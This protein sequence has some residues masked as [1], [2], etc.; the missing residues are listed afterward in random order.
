MNDTIHCSIL[1][2][3]QAVAFCLQFQAQAVTGLPGSKKEGGIRQRVSAKIHFNSLHNKFNNFIITFVILSTFLKI[4]PVIT[5]IKLLATLLEW[6][7]HL[8]CFH[9]FNI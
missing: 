3:V 5:L 9:Q 8:F 7:I 4:T 2:Q 1:A 6:I